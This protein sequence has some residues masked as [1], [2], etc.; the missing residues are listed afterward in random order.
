[1]SLTLVPGAPVSGDS[2]LRT[3]IAL[4]PAACA[5]VEPS[6]PLFLFAEIPGTSALQDAGLGSMR[7]G[8]RVRFNEARAAAAAR[9]RSQSEG[10]ESDRA[11]RGA[12]GL[13]LA[14]NRLEPTAPEAAVIRS[15]N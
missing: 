15:T 14:W 9:G 7:V 3:E 1:M 11:R 2:S 13:R 8:F 6:L 4:Q 5:G 10:R 12:S